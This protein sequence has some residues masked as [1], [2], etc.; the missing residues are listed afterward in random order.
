LPVSLPRISWFSFEPG[1]SV[2]QLN[3]GNNKMNFRITEFYLIYF[4]CRNYLKLF[5]CVLWIFY[6]KLFCFQD[7]GN[8]AN[9]SQGVALN[10][11]YVCDVLLICWFGTQLIQD[12]RVN[13]LTLLL[14]LQRH[15]ENAA[16][17]RQITNLEL[18]SVVDAFM[19]SLGFN[20]QKFKRN[21]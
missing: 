5:H 12:V 15:V 4:L 16:S 2:T 17:F 9:M 14:F 20:C 7:W 8:Y 11:I 19:Y 21:M 1:S 18:L 10:V 13:G 3:P 6:Y